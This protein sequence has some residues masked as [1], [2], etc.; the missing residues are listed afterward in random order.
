MGDPVWTGAA[1]R[2]WA[3]V[4]GLPPGKREQRLFLMLQAFIDDSG[5]GQD[6]AF[7]LAGYIAPAERWA[8]FSKDWQEILDLARYPYF[9]MSEWGDRTDDEKVMFFY[10]V[11]ERYVTAGIRCV[12]PHQ[13]FREAIRYLERFVPHL[14]GE[15][16]HDD[17]YYFNLVNLVATIHHHKAHLGITEKLKLIFDKQQHKDIQVLQN[18]ERLLKNNPAFLDTVDG[19]PGFE[20]DKDFLPLQAADMNAWWTRRRFETGRQDVD[21]RYPWKAKAS[22]PHVE[23]TF[24]KETILADFFAPF[25]YSGAVSASLLTNGHL[26]E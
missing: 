19:V 7:V 24:D 11:I 22:V 15:M 25:G 2:V 23:V 9:K 4:S 5:T 6:S 10:R 26:V 18:W 3:M 20:D 12:V 13:D 8:D 14:T 16:R 17:I 1:G 21:D